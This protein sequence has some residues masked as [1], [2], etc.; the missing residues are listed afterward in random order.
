MSEHGDHA[1]VASY[2]SHSV[3]EHAVRQL[4]QSGFPMHQLSI[5]GRDWHGRENVEGFYIPADAVKEGARHAAWVGGFFGLFMGMGMFV[6]PIG[7]TLMVL[8]PL[9]GAIAGAIGGAGIGALVS[10]LMTLGVPKDQA[11]RYQERIEA[12]EFLVVV[13][14]APEIA[15]RAHEVLQETS[16]TSL[17]KHGDPKSA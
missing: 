17:A 7:G 5:V 1:V 16:T 2:N 12:G 6:L 3:A 15:A 11:L 8:G 4:Q 13:Q 10:S 14:G 9:A